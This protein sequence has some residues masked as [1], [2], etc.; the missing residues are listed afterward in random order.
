VFQYFVYCQMLVFLGVSLFAKPLLAL[1]AAPAF[2]EAASII[3]IVC[4]AYLLFSLHEHFK[5]PA[6]LAKRT[7]TLLPGVVTAAAANIVLN[8]L[9]I[10]LL[11][12]SGAAW[13]SVLTF[14][15]FSFL[16]LWRYRLID[17]YEYPFRRCGAVLIGM[18][19]SYL[20]FGLL[21]Y[22]G[23]SAFWLLAFSILIWC[24]WLIF[25]FGRATGWLAI[26]G[27]PEG[28]PSRTPAVMEGGI[29][30]AS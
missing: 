30:R 7:L 16:G 12:P 11:G 22:L 18:C 15:I 29:R 3:P 6:L 5:V 10:P 19:T 24:S 23:L 9:L 1:V 28:K 14:A 26:R 20:V 21:N 25:L 13:A 27:S 17:R 4:L 2:G 8:L